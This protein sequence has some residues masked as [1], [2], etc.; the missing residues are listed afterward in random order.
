MFCPRRTKRSAV[1]GAAAPPHLRAQP[2]RAEVQGAQPQ[3][4][5]AEQAGDLAQV[6]RAQPQP[7]RVDARRQLRGV[8]WPHRS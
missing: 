7:A 8:L 4:R 5:G 6:H 2:R 3:A 1:G